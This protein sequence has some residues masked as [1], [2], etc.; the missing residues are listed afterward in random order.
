M[1]GLTLRYSNAMVC[2]SSKLFAAA[3]AVVGVFVLSPAAALADSCGG[4]SAVNIY[5]ECQPSASGG[6]HHTRSG[7][8]KQTTSTAPTYPTYQVVPVKHHTGVPRNSLRRPIASVSNAMKSVVRFVRIPSRGVT[9]TIVVR[10]SYP[11]TKPTALS[12]VADLGAG[13]TALFAMLAMLAIVFLGS[14][15]LRGRRR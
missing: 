10:A 7:V 6:T 9:P 14:G 4:T 8:H 2:R 11:T 15:I 12:A 3:I 13:P 1:F 5:S